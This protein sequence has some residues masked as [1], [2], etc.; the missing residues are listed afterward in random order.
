MGAVFETCC[1]SSKNSGDTK[2]KKEVS[3]D[4]MKK[5][6]KQI[7]E[8]INGKQD[9]RD[10]ITEFKLTRLFQSYCEQQIDLKNMPS[11]LEEDASNTFTAD[12][13]QRIF[14]GAFVWKNMCV[15]QAKNVFIKSRRKELREGNNNEYKKIIGLMHK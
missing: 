7:D 14:M 10:I 15:D 2:E 1:K 3:E 9:Y 6:M 13:V 5:A 8:M 4:E 12:F 11:Y